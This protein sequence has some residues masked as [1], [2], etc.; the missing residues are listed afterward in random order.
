MQPSIYFYIN[1]L[2][3]QIKDAQSAYPE[4]P[5]DNVRFTQDEIDLYTT[6]TKKMIKDLVQRYPDHDIFGVLKVKN[7]RYDKAVVAVW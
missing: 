4:L 5:G 6:N 2:N 3:A 1:K 7:Q